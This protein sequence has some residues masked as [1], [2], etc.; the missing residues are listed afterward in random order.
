VAERVTGHGELSKLMDVYRRK[1]GSGSRTRA[2]TRSSPSILG[3]CSAS[4]STIRSSLAA[5]PAGSSAADWACCQP[6]ARVALG[7]GGVDA[8][9][10]TART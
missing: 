2:K 3:L 10:H 6:T 7:A 1:Y 4:S 9:D 5:P 8:G